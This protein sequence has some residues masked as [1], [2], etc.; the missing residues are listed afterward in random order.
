MFA[1]FDLIDRI[2]SRFT[3]PEGVTV[4]I[5]DDGAVLDP[6][7]F[8][9]VTCD[10]LVEGVHFRRDWSSAY[11]IGWKT[12]AT[13]LSDIAAMGGGPGVFFLSIAAPRDEDEAFID[14]LLDG[15]HAACSELVPD[16]FQVSIGGGDLTSTPGPLSLT[17]T[18]LGESSPAGPLLRSGAVP[19]DRVIVIGPLGLSRAG[20][21]ILS[22]EVDVDPADFE[23]LVTAHRRPTPRVHEGAVLGLY[24][25]PSSLID[26]SDG[27]AQDLSH[28]LRRSDVGATIETHG[29]PRHPQLVALGEAAEID[30]TPW[31]L[32]GGED[33]ELLMTVPPARMPKL[34]E[35]ARRYH[36]HVYDIGEVRSASEG[37]RLLSPDGQLLELEREGFQH[38]AGGR[39]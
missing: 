31:I 36:W 32:S 18:L 33:F 17:V 27:L 15:M 10:T 29:L 12:I 34:W 8:D 35:L 19:G 20:L 2:A 1:E 30:V 39:G 28:V 38:F 4:G 7:R 3:T 26:I 21:A 25:V 14:E 6:G 11:D 9:L 37:L 5:G 24:G 13:N 23:E 22:G 16:S